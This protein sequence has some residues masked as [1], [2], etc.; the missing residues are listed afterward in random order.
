MFGIGFFPITTSPIVSNVPEAAGHCFAVEGVKR[1]TYLRWRS[2]MKSLKSIFARAALPAVIL[3]G[4]SH[5]AIAQT[6]DQ[7]QTVQAAHPSAEAM[8]LRQQR[9]REMIKSQAELPPPLTLNAR[10]PSEEA[11]RVRQSL[12]EI[13]KSQAG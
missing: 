5:E 2:H 1:Q 4:L 13:I 8:H 10:P 7:A 12:R 9:L 3:L 6:T 11:L